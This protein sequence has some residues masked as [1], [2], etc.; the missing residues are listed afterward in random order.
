MPALC[1]PACLLRLHT[2]RCTAKELT[3]PL[4]ADESGEVS[5]ARG[6]DGGAASAKIKAKKQTHHVL[7]Q[8]YG[9]D[10][11]IPFFG[12]FS[13]RQTFLIDAKGVIVGHWKESDGS[14]A[15]DAAQTR[16]RR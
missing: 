3:F 10:L 7:S 16:L 11:S 6:R 2:H 5:K 13:D 1:P 8:S 14:S 9:A 12:K 15:S 4:L